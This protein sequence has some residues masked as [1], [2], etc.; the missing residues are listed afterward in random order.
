M[1]NPSNYRDMTYLDIKRF[2]DP[3]RWKE[4]IDEKGMYACTLAAM[5][6]LMRTNNFCDGLA[7]TLSLAC[8]PSTAGAI[9]G[10]LAGALYGVEKIPWKLSD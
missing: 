5:W 1:M 2:N 8:E 3:Y 4:H 6:S 7:F 9:F 10:Q